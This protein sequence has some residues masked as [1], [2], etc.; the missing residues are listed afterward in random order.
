MTAAAARPGG[1]E[2]TGLRGPVR[3]A[4]AASFVVM[5][6]AG[7]GKAP[8]GPTM[9]APVA[10]SAGDTSVPDAASVFAP[11]SASASS[12]DASAGRSNRPMSGAQE[13]AAMP[14]PGQNNDHS[15]PLGPA[16]PASGQ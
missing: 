13:S 11:A 15:A 12:A 6:L 4:A 9:P 5:A 3:A 10:A 16:R 7:C 8:A 1:D 14:M 2:G